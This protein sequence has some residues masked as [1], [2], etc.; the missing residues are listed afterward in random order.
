[1]DAGVRPLAL[2]AGEARQAVALVAADTV[3]THAAVLA[4]KRLAVVHVGIAVIAGPAVDAD[5]RVAASVRTN[6]QE[7]R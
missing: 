3:V 2:E 5:A 6:I 1:M 7:Q 4:E